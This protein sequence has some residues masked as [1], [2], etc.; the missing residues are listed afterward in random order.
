[1]M[2]YLCC[3]KWLLSAMAI[4]AK[5]ELY[6][7][8]KDLKSDSFFCCTG[9]GLLWFFAWRL[10]WILSVPR[11]DG[12]ERCCCSTAPV[13][14]APVYLSN[15]MFTGPVEPWDQLIS[16]CVGLPRPRTEPKAASSLDQLQTFGIFTS[17]CKTHQG[18][19]FRLG[20][21][22]DHNFLC[23]FLSW[24]YLAMLFYV[25]N[26]ILYNIWSCIVPRSV[27]Y[28]LYNTLVFLNV[29]YK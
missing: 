25:M 7:S 13:L 24:F 18:F 22:P 19:T 20:L 14:A 6:L 17:A 16:G 11:A 2:D 28:N 21:N 1:M 12:A 26:F 4:L 8:T 9:T 27:W 15:C 5:V 10:Q 3:K 23:F 29:F